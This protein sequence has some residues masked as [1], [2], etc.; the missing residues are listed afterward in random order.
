LPVLFRG[1]IRRRIVAC[2]FACIQTGCSSLTTTVFEAPRYLLGASIVFACPMS[3][4]LYRGSCMFCGARSVRQ[5][6]WASRGVTRGVTV[7]NR[8]GA[9]PMISYE[10]Y[11]IRGVDWR[12]T[13]RDKP[14]MPLH[15][16]K[17]YSGLNEENC[18]KNCSP[19]FQVPG[20]E[21]ASRG[22]HDVY[23]L[24]KAPHFKGSLTCGRT[25]VWIPPR[26]VS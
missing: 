23:H 16:N 20:D 1:F 6:R 12:S 24:A 19:V 11:A 22:L 2:G 10:A 13:F 17:T 4:L 21:A 7:P 14:D 15:A 25:R 18:Y 5:R 9:F 26:I 8:H 3:S